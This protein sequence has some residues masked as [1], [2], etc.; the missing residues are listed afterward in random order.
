MRLIPKQKLNALEEKVPV[1][2]LRQV[3]NL[4]KDMKNHIADAKTDYTTGDLDTEAEIIA[5]INA[6]NTTLNTLL[7]ELESYKILRSS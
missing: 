5:A 1:G 2:L 7:A 3:V 4:E 6:T